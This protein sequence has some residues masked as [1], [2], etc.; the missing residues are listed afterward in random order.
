MQL[1]S[2]ALL[3]GLF[4]RMAPHGDPWTFVFD[5]ADVPTRGDLTLRHDTLTPPDETHFVHAASAVATRAGVRAF[6]YR[7]RYEGAYNGQIMSSTFDGSKWSEATEVINAGTISHETGVDFKS[8]ANPVPFHPT[9]SEL[10]LFF[11]ASRLSGWATCEILLIKSHDDGQTWGPPQ[12][13]YASPMLNMSNL[14]KSVPVR[15]SGGRFVLPAYHEFGTKYPV[16]FV[17][18]QDGQI[19]DRRRMGK[20][21][22]VG[23]QPSIVPTS[24]TTAVAFVRRLSSHRPERMRITHT[25]DG[26]N[27]WTTVGETTLPNPGGAISAIPYGKEHVLLAYNDDP[28]MERNVGLAVSDLSGTHWKRLGSVA[29]PN[30]FM[31]NDMVMYPYVIQSQPGIFDVFYSRK[32]KAIDHVRVDS[33]WIEDRLQ[34]QANWK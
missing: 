31:P 32:R 18:N 33:A 13:L 9:P 16:M 34:R 26:G 21:G 10:W 7:A 14:T 1:V 19:V 22:L 28:E 25:I 6:W 27:T 5:P 30:A 15:L 4:I 23:F 8:L 3:V 20:G 2:A 29:R 12:R 24:A 11:S 17:L